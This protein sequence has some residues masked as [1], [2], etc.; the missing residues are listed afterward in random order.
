MD[1]GTAYAVRTANTGANGIGVS[2]ELAHTVDT[3]GPEAVAHVLKIRGGCEGGGK[4][5]LVGDDLSFTISTHQDQTLFQ[6]IEGENNVNGKET[7]PI[8]DMRVLWETTASEADVDRQVGV[9]ARLQEAQVLRPEVHGRC[10]RGPDKN[11]QAVVDDRTLSCPKD[12]SARSMRD[13]RQGCE[14]GRASQERGLARQ[15]ARESYPRLQELSYQ[16]ASSEGS[17]QDMWQASEGAGVLREALPEVQEIRESAYDRVR[18]KA[19]GEEAGGH[20]VIR[21][22]TPV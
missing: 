11:G 21:R 9:N 20:Y 5:A 8:Q 15:L 14:D 10:V 2:E 17:L 13:M 19:V 22:L 1:E 4:G 16:A 7:R 6:W 12:M 3:N 18:D